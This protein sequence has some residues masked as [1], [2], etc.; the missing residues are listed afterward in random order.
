M[1][2]VEN[3]HLEKIQDTN[4]QKIILLMD[5]LKIKP[6]RE[7]KAMQTE[8]QRIGSGILGILAA[9]TII[10]VCCSVLV[11]AKEIFWVIL[12]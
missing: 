4:H 11:L 7:R 10:A 9:L 5:I 12:N 6:K 2:V 1:F 3:F 8:M